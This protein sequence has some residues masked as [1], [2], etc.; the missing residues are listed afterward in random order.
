MACHSTALFTRNA[1]AARIVPVS[2]SRLSRRFPLVE[3]DRQDPVIGA[4]LQPDLGQGAGQV[5]LKKVADV[6]TVVIDR[7]DDGRAGDQILE[8]N[9]VPVFVGEGQVEG[10]VVPEPFGETDILG[11]LGGGMNVSG[12][13]GGVIVAGRRPDRLF[14]FGRGGE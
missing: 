8:L 1:R 13:S 10:D 11:G 5:G 12:G 2:R 4:R 14:A 7:G 9:R 6:R 3:T